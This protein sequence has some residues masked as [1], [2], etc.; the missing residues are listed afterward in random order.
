[1]NQA[2]FTTGLACHRLVNC[3]T[4]ATMAL[5]LGVSFFGL[6]AHYLVQLI[7]YPNGV[8]LISDGSY[9]NEQKQAITRILRVGVE[10]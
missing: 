5:D 8:P 9:E 10:G 2:I 1:M 7:C 6:Q 3:I 4:V